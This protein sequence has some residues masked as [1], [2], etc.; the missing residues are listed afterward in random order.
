MSSEVAEVK[1]FWTELEVLRDQH[2]LSAS[3]QGEGHW[4]FSGQLRF[5]G[6]WKG[7]I[8]ASKD[9]SLQLLKGS[10]VSGEIEVPH[11]IVEGEISQC[12]LRCDYILLKKGAKVNGEIHSRTL[13][14][15]EGALIEADFSHQGSLPRSTGEGP[16]V[17]H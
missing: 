9:A 14:V 8:S 16:S 3:F 5:A 10:H 2:W 7:R 12:R 11:L 15:E 6:Q 1:E 13:V 17:D 4:N